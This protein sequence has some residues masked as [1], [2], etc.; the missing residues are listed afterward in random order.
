MLITRWLM[1][2]MFL[3]QFSILRCE[4]SCLRV[5]FQDRIL[6]A[7]PPSLVER[8]VEGRARVQAQDGGMLIE[9]QAGCLW[10]ITASQSPVI[11]KLTVP[12]T[13]TDQKT[14][15]EQLQKE[16]GEQ[17]SIVQT[18]HYVICTSAGQGYGEWCGGLFE[19]LHGGFHRFW[20]DRIPNLNP[21][22]HPLVAIAFRN[23]EEFQKFQA[24]DA[25]GQVALAQGYFNARTNRMILF[26]QSGLDEGQS[27]RK[28]ETIQKQALRQPGVITTVIHEAVHQLAFN[29]G[30]QVRYADNPSWFSEGMAMY[31][32]AP[33]LEARSGWRTIG[34][35]H[36][37]RLDRYRSLTKNGPPDIQSLISTDD[38]FRDP[39]L[40][41]DAYA[42][43]WALHFF[44][45]RTKKEQYN[46][47]VD[48]LG[49][50]TPLAFDTPEKRIEEFESCFGSLEAV[51]KDLAR[52]MSRLRGGR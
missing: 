27:Q 41:L 3:S 22:D 24:H 8:T 11:E 28:S 20:K 35:I 13:Y 5:R 37:G 16:F 17:F 47:Y 7:G 32:E 50:K 6:S 44:L 49:A 38:R 21:P 14:I 48:I 15:A 33:D 29:S 1:C 42:E 2:L 46:Q 52:Y 9:D 51:Q 25:Q 26:D 39:Q 36:P 45:I 4:D 12:F 34:Q 10:P 31:F 23:S 40:A 19:R 18:P 30:I 43:A